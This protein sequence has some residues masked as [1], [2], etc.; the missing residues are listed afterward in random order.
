M[1]IYYRITYGLQLIAA[2]NVLFALLL[3]WHTETGA[4]IEL[5]QEPFRDFTFPTS[6]TTPWWPLWLLPPVAII[7]LIRGG[8][9]VFDHQVMWGRAALIASGVAIVA[10]LWFYAAFGQE[11]DT[12]L[13]T[14]AGDLQVG[15]WLTA[16]SL[17]IL[18]VLIVV[19]W[20]LPAKDPH[21]VRLS[22]LDANDPDRLWEGHFRICGYCGSPNDPEARRCDYCGTALFP[23]SQK[24]G[25]T[26]KT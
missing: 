8:L 11:H 2:L 5:M 4:A 7:S 14:T 17:A 9:G 12:S 24:Q 20:T 13:T 18:S 25:D 19:E 6:L 16:S 23:E 21:L 1:V 15:Y 26:P 10:M 22:R 3:S